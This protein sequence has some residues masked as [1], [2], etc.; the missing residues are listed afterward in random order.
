MLQKSDYP[1][2]NNRLTHN[3]CI[4]SGIFRIIKKIKK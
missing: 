1:S 3:N 2:V 4:T